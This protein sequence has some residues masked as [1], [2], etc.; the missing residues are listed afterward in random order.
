[1]AND[2][3]STLSDKIVELSLSPNSENLDSLRE[4]LI[5]L[6]NQLINENFDA[7][8]QLLYRID[9][10]EKK[11]R[12]YLLEKPNENSAK[13]LADLI[14]ERQL[15]KAETRIKYKNQNRDDSTEERW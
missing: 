6:I 10:S 7:L 14:I 4:N 5:P 11:I 3:S 12:N 2:K 8:V 1:M 9:V 15:Q 13:V